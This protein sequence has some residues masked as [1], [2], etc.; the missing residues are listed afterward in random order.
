MALCL[1]FLALPALFVPY[2]SYYM[3]HAIPPFALCVAIQMRKYPWL[4]LIIIPMIVFAITTLFPLW[5]W[6]GVDELG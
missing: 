2:S 5:D 4:A 1:A 6:N 3:V